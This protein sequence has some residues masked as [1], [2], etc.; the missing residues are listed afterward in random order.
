[1][2][3][4]AAIFG[5][6]LLIYYRITKYDCIILQK[7]ATNYLVKHRIFLPISVKLPN[8]VNQLQERTAA[9]Y[10]SSNLL[11]YVN[12]SISAFAPFIRKGF[13][14]FN[15]AD[16]LVNPVFRIAKTAVVVD[17]LLN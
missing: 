5:T 6:N 16:T 11:L 7:Y 8:R 2:A 9:T 4:N 12:D 14:H 13:A 17:G 10:Y 3:Y 1:M 15:G